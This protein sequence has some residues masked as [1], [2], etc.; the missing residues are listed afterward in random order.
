M[1]KAAPKY[2]KAHGMNYAQAMQAMDSSFAKIADALQSLP[3]ETSPEQFLATLL[4]LGLIQM[5]YQDHL[6]GFV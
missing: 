1:M 5:R 3:K 4:Q 6:D 2:M